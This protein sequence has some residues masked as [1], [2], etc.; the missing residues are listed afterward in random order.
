[1]ESLFA[2][3]LVYPTLFYIRYHLSEIFLLGV[4]FDMLGG[5]DVWYPNIGRYVVEEC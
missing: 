1:M 5:K 3:G 2:I 4:L